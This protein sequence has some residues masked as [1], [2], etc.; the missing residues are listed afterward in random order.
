MHGL[1]VNCASATCRRVLWFPNR[2]VSGVSRGLQQLRLLGWVWVPREQRCLP[3][4]STLSFSNSGTHFTG[5][6]IWQVCAVWLDLQVS[7]QLPPS[8]LWVRWLHLVA[9]LRLNRQNFGDLPNTLAKSIAIGP[10]KC[11]IHPFWNSWTFTLCDNHRMPSAFGSCFFWPTG[12]KGEILQ[13]CR[14]LIASIKSNC[15]GRTILS[16]CDFRRQR[17]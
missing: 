2:D 15:F 1:Q 12:D 8:I 17:V 4:T 11:Q 9:L 13:Y 10:F 14:S 7:L 3:P 6:V 16:Q 5:Q